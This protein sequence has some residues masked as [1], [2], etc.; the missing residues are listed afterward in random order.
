MGTPTARLLVARRYA[1]CEGLARFTH[2]DAVVLEEA[3]ARWSKQASLV[4]AA[5]VGVRVS[6]RRLRRT[7]QVL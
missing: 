2:G 7:V 3:I 5:G 1:Q 4:T 6:P